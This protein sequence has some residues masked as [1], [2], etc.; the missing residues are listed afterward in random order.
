MPRPRKTKITGGSSELSWEEV[1]EQFIYYIRAQGRAERTVADYRQH[2]NALFK[3]T[4]SVWPDRVKDAVYKYLA[5]DIKPATYNMRRKY[6]KVFFN[7]CVEEGY[8]EKNPLDGTKARK[9][10]GR[11]VNID[12][13]VIEELLTLPNKKTFSGL[14]DLALL[15]LTLDTG[16]R[17][18]EAFAL[19]PG[20]INT[21]SREIYIRQDV[22]K[23]RV[24]R[25]LVVSPQVIVSIRRLLDARLP[26]WGKDVPVFCTYEG[27]KMTRHRWN[28]RLRIYCSRLK[29]KG[30]KI[31][32]YDLR[33][34]FALEYLRGGGDIYHL[35][36]I[37]GH[38]DL[39]MTKHY[40][41]ITQSDLRKQHDICSP[42]SRLKPIK[43]RAVRIDKKE[44]RN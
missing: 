35:Q 27:T 21:K 13:E 43:R 40:L 3:R 1:I 34:F 38:T 15:E 12:P 8:I 2:I 7:W 22:S 25:T 19:L 4:P 31:R 41:A 32:P 14:R 16:I 18:G 20:D 36:R 29:Q 11:V 23:T 10:P 28:D 5:D 26:E 33:H 42:L 6:L 17:P 30:A 24:P 37:M 44:K 39:T 9:D